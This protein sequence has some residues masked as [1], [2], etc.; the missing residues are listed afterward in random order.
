MRRSGRIVLW[1]AVLLFGAAARAA[2]GQVT[3]V[4]SVR[5][6]LDF[7]NAPLQTVI[8]ALAEAGQLDVAFGQ[9]PD[10]TI[11]LRLG[12]PLRPEEVLPLLRTVA[13]ANGLE[14][15]QSERLVLVR[16]PESEVVVEQAEPDG[17]A[18]RRVYVY[19]LRHTRAP[20]LAQTL[21]ALF[22]GGA[23]GF[24]AGTLGPPGASQPGVEQ[25]RD[26][27]ALGVDAVTEVGQVLPGELEGN[28][29]IVADDPTNS[30]LVRASQADWAVIEQSLQA[31]DQRPLQVLIEML[32][33][34]VRHDREID[35]GVSF[36]TTGPIEVPGG[37]TVEGGLRSSTDGDLF[38]SARELAGLELEVA[39]SLL[40]ASGDV[41]ILSRPV[42][43]AQNNQ[44][45]RILIGSERP[46]IQV[47]RSL[48]TEAAVRDQIV[49][50][51]DIGTS[52]SI[53]P[54]IYADGYVNLT[55]FQEVSTATSEVQFGAPVISTREAQAQ[56]FA[57]AG[58]TVVMGGLIDE[59]RVTTRS[60]IP[61]LKD[62]PILGYLFGSTRDRRFQ[63]ELF[64]FL[65]AHV[66]ETDEDVDRLMDAIEG[67]V[68][69]LPALPPPLFRQSEPDISVP[70][71][72]PLLAPRD[73][74]DAM[75]AS[76]APPG[77]GGRPG[78]RR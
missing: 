42:I 15:V 6:V 40:A 5:A 31:L 2:V 35:A 32:I 60:G 74:V 62:I 13:E 52:L 63:S 4:D 30:I 41:H 11:T 34:E 77:R 33:V 56:L 10:R 76:S 46:F 16:L 70:S 38:V 57:R 14:L 72:R 1:S 55:V 71:V 7:Q 28:L 12:S 66:V 47:F 26:L 27:F 78:A 50:Y 54:T 53:V 68:D 49:Q 37:G 73:T 51:R 39:L 9:L 58:Q 45:S 19:R 44:E 75:G 22:G 43:L 61:L 24:S 67:A 18:V 69:M 3:P 8:T 20:A 65:T 23:S 64:L 21:R 36:E 59:Q 17:T 29:Q 25:G 48:P